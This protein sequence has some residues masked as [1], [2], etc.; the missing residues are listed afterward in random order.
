MTD[1]AFFKSRV[2]KLSRPFQNEDGCIRYKHNERLT[3]G[4]SVKIANSR[5]QGTVVEAGQID[6]ITRCEMVVVL[7]NGERIRL[8]EDTVYRV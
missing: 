5:E 8:A 1:D 2:V 4:E 3:L 7:V 6:L